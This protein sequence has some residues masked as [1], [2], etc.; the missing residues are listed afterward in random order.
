VSLIASPSND[1]CGAAATL[2][3]DT[4]VSGTTVTA[5]DDARLPS[6]SPC[7][8]GIGQT[9]STA[10][11]VDV[12]YRFTAPGDGRYSFRLTGY[13][14]SKN[15]VLYVAS[16]CP[17]GSPPGLVAG[18]LGGANRTVTSPEEVSCLPLVS[19]QTV[20]VYVDE[21]SLTTGS[22]FTREV[23][24]CTSE[25]EPNGAPSSA[26]A[27]ACGLEGSIAPSGDVDFFSLGIPEAG[28]R[29]FALVDGAA[30]N[31]GD[32]DLR[33]TTGADTLEYDDF[34]NDTP[35]GAASPNVSGTRA[36]GAAAYLRVS[37][38]SAAALAEPYRL[39]ASVQ[40]PST[41]ATVEVEPNDSI[42]TATF[43][44]NEYFSGS[45][46]GP[47]DVDLFSFPAVAGE[48]IQIGLDLDPT[49]GNSPFNGS[50]ALLD[51]SG[52]TL[53]LVNDPAF[54]S[55]VASG[56]GSLTATTPSSPGEAVVYRI[57]FGGTYYAKVAWSS[58]TP[59]DYLLSITHDC[60]ARSAGPV[61]GDGDGVQDAD[62]CAPA[63]PTSWAVPGEATGLAF[64]TT[65][66]TSLR[67]VAPATP[68]GTEV[69]YDLLRSAAA[70]SFLTPTC[71]LSRTTATSGIDATLPAKAF[72]YL[73]RSRNACGDDLGT[74]S[75]G[76]PRPSG[77]CP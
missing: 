72:Y 66:T 44:A 34:N 70:G 38:Y 20:Y 49:R 7:F 74:R 9:A 2:T 54:S 19:G 39:Y 77:S 73:A 45:L 37:H 25:T 71:L 14:P 31:S 36:T 65:D 53:L 76:T 62:D 60:R 24:R 30:G 3:L 55:T 10:S 47:S 57:R 18:C 35:F 28:S 12:A 64:P 4:P 52:T 23:N 61:D 51:A 59:G 68:G 6:G 33:V 50:L 40:P 67:W 26:G 46:S 58:G 13:D 21:D 63:D 41:A 15:A 42:A 32:F 8:T 22:G 75:D 17:S 69:R 43:G 29:I 56:S 16:D 5:S 27:I 48:L 11:G 1:T